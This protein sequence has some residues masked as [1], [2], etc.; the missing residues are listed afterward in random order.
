MKSNA[1]R[2]FVEFKNK[3]QFASMLSKKS[4]QFKKRLGLETYTEKKIASKKGTDCNGHL[5]E[6][7][8]EGFNSKLIIKQKKH[9]INRKLNNL[10]FKI[11]N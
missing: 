8:F 1:R 9:R 4:N 7:H 11:I 3:K 5:A 6:I 2:Q 10:P